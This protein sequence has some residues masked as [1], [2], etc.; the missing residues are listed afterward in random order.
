MDNESEVKDPEQIR[1]EMAETRANL[2]DK[3]EKLEQQVVGTVHEATSAVSETVAT[4]KEAVQETV[5]SV[6]DTLHD[7][8]EGVRETFNISRQVERHPCLMMCASVATGY[9]LGALLIPKRHHA[10]HDSWRSLS[11]PRSEWSRSSAREEQPIHEYRATKTHAD[12]TEGLTQKFAPEI[13]RLKGLAIGYLVGA[14]RDLVAPSL[15]H[16]MRSH[17]SQMADD[18]ATKLGG[19]PMHDP[20]LQ[21]AA[22]CTHSEHSR[23]EERTTSG[24]YTEAS[25]RW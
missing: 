21:G 3:V 6:K 20:V 11:S 13:N 2:T 18:I 25:A 16:E 4:V 23:A 14:I 15:P 19:Q 24:S 1:Q 10:S 8:V 7:T 12:F 9:A 22:G 5:D 17:V